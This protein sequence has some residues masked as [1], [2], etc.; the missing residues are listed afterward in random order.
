MSTR[1]RDQVK[2]LH[3]AVRRPKTPVNGS[4]QDPRNATLAPVIRRRDPVSASHSRG[5]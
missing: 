2:P 1:E 3:G 4:S 5:K